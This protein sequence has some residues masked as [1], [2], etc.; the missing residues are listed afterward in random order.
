[1]EGSAIWQDS[2]DELGEVAPLQPNPPGS[3]A[4]LSPHPLPFHS[5]CQLRAQEAACGIP[6]ELTVMKSGQERLRQKT[7]TRLPVWDTQVQPPWAGA[8][9][10]LLLTPPAGS[11]FNVIRLSRARK[12][13]PCSR[14]AVRVKKTHD[15]F[16]AD[17]SEG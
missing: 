11:Q 15:V 6:A 7:G 12:L 4:S 9:P 1:M 8:Q 2:Q 10:A 3:Q 5:A 13:S 17:D 16:L 14:G